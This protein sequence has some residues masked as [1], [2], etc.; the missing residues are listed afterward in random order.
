MSGHAR[1]G[2]AGVSRSGALM[3]KQA[4]IARLKGQ[5]SPATKV[6]DRFK[7]VENAT[8][9]DEEEDDEEEEEEENNNKRGSDKKGI[10]NSAS[11][12]WTTEEQNIIFQFYGMD[13]LFPKVWS[14]QPV[15]QLV[16]AGDKDNSTNSPVEQDKSDPLKIRESNIK[17]P[18]HS[19]KSE[20][21]I[22]IFDKNFNPKFFL[23]EVHKNADYKDL[24]QGVKRLK[25]SI[26]E[27]NDIAK[28]LVK[29]HFAKFVNAKTF[30]KEMKAKNL[31]SH[32]DFGIGPFNTAVEAL[33]IQALRLYGPILERRLKAD[34][35]RIT[36]SILEQWKFFF[37]LARSLS[38]MVRAGRF[39]AA[40]RDYKKG[41][42]LMESSFEKD[43]SNITSDFKK[44]AHEP[45]T[46]LPKNYRNVFEQLWQE[47]EIVVAKFRDELFKSLSVVSTPIETQEKIIGYLVDLDAK[48]DPIWCYLETQYNYVVENMFE[49]YIKYLT[50]MRDVIDD[51]NEEIPDDK[52]SVDPRFSNLSISNIYERA[53]QINGPADRVVFPSLPWNLDDLKKALNCVTTPS[54]ETLFGQWSL[55]L[56]YVMFLPNICHVFGKHVECTKQSTA[57][58]IKDG[59]AMTSNIFEILQQLLRA[60]LFVDGKKNNDDITGSSMSVD[61]AQS[62]ILKRQSSV[63][64]I[65]DKD[66][67]SKYDVSHIL[68]KA[69]RALELLDYL[70]PDEYSVHL[71][72]NPLIMVHY[73][74]RI[75]EAMNSCE[76]TVRPYYA[77]E[78]TPNNLMLLNSSTN[79]LKKSLIQCICNSWSTCKYSTIDLV[80]VSKT[81]HEFEDW[82]FENCLSKTK[83]KNQKIRLDST[84]LIKHSNKMTHFILKSLGLIVNGVHHSTTK[85]ET[86]VNQIKSFNDNHI[87]KIRY[88]LISTLFSQLDAAEWQIALLRD[89]ASFQNEG[90]AETVP[91]RLRIAFENENLKF[92]QFFPAES[93]NY[94]EHIK[95]KDYK[96]FVIPFYV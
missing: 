3:A 70:E 47:V 14:E 89:T 59:Q 87:D 68:L 63:N 73:A 50:D 25:E 12:N 31:I 46:L 54:F 10:T 48:Q 53:D 51:L 43:D 34:R 30:Y 91:N 13:C 6:P 76:E 40:V 35:I 84:H 83:D 23:V 39:D 8:E 67:A 72:A 85:T 32:K 37:N 7:I 57:K 4:S 20:H 88:T 75:M 95:P 56:A 44:P 58:R 94:F 17:R 29:K 11:L 79:I 27:K 26:T 61:S 65:N 18:K 82:S 33:E 49:V 81:F 92:G 36:L 74:T 28:G 21:S 9:D 38:D 2:S 41:K 19:K 5:Q 80:L 90:L 96:D 22:Y 16:K 62:Q 60:A 42:N 45:S 15:N 64:S 55:L 77:S 52:V 93:S 78:E 66:D 86:D 71:K 1:T 69:K 24:E